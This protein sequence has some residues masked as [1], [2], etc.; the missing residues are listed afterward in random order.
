MGVRAGCP[1]CPDPGQLC[2][3][4]LGAAPGILPGRA[5][6]RAGRS[7]QPGSSLC[8]P[9]LPSRCHTV[10]TRGGLPF[11]STPS[12][13]PAKENHLG[14][15]WADSHNWRKRLS[16]LILT[17]PELAGPYLVCSWGLLEGDRRESGLGPDGVGSQ[18]CPYYIL[19]PSVVISVLFSSRFIFNSRWLLYL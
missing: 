4:C 15:P 6:W 9:Q 13:H 5:R 11:P 7:Q 19:F 8:T 18:P 14:R 16:T 10:G 17:V 12:S 2:V 1:A 3:G